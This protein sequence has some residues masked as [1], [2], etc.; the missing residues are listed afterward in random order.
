MSTS[1]HYLLHSCFNSKYFD[2]FQACQEPTKTTWKT[3][4]R[5]KLEELRKDK[6]ANSPLIAYYAPN[7]KL[8]DN[9]SA[10]FNLSSSSFRTILN[11]RINRTLNYR[12]CQCGSTFSRSH[13]SCYLQ[14]HPL[15]QLILTCPRFKAQ[16]K[17][18]P[19]NYNA[20]DHLL[21]RNRY[22]DFLN[23]YATLANL[24]DL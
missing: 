8:L 3:W 7:L 13:I 6:S 20:M 10:I 9:S 24:I 19:Q 21:N 5:N 4:K 1:S 11:W 23:L 2:Q 14:E 15:Y 18:M 16:A 22:D 17:L 12:N